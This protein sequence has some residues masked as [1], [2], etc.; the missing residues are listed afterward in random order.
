MAEVVFVVDEAY[1]R[2][3]IASLLYKMLIKLARESG[4]KGFIAEVL[5]SNVGIM[6][7]FQKGDLPVKAHLESGVYHLTI[8]LDARN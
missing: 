1:Q 2:L 7:V 3:G 4:V 8:P 5:F 6:N